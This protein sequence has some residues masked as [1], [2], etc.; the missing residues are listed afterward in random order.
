MNILIDIGHPAHVHYFKLI[1]KYFIGKNDSVLFVTRDKE[2]TINLLRHYNFNF[3]NIGKFYTSFLGKIWGLFWFT[4][5]L[6]LI[7]LKFKPDVYL[8]ATFYSSFVAWI[9]RKPHI[10]I[11]DTFNKESTSLFM[12]FTSIV[13]TGDYPHP[14]LGAKE[15]SVSAY[16]ELLYLHPKYFVP[17]KSVLNELKVNEKEKYVIMRFVSWKATHDAGHKGISLENKVRAVREFGKYGKVFI[18][19]EAEL[20]AE[21]NPYKINIAPHKMHDAI[22][23][24]SLIIGESFTML[25]EAA[26]LGTP[27][28]LIHDTKCYYLQEQ[29]NKYG[30]TF[31]Y[32][33]SEEDQLK[34][35]NKGIEILK[36][37]NIKEKWQGRREKM[38]NDK[39]DFT[40]F[41]IWFVENYPGSVKIIKENPDYQRR[42]VGLS[43]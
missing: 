22:A 23:F 35:I 30:L 36:T 10:S 9:L 16:Q 21:L 15:I 43:D 7:A 41:L 32:T 11:E 27:A 40:A 34:A 3:I 14:S 5:K 37:P 39:I 12:P 38:L 26:V 6:G 28:V 2:V 29:Q 31:N 24:A 8:N 18:S 1:A 42:F 20:P 13:I 33:E 17:D 19:S 4:I 25:S